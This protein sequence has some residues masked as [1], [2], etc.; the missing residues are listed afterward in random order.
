METNTNTS[1]LSFSKG[2]TT[3][4]SGLLSEDS[5]LV[6]SRN[7]IYR[8]GE[9]KP[10]QKPV[11]IG[12]VSADQEIKFIHKTAGY[13]NVITYDGSSSV[14]WYKKENGTIGSCEG[15]FN[16]G[17]VYDINAVGNT[18]VVATEKGLHYLLFKSGKYKDLGTELPIPEFHPW[19]TISN[20]LMQGRSPATLYGCTSCAKTKYGYYVDED[21]KPYV[22]E[23]HTKPDEV[24]SA[25]GIVNTLSDYYKISLP[26]DD[27]QEYIDKVKTFH[28]SLQGHVAEAINIAKE[29]NKFVG[30]FFIRFALKLFDGSY[31]RISNPIACYPIIRRGGIIRG[32]YWNT[33]DDYQW[34]YIV[35]SGRHDYWGTFM[36]QIYYG[37]LGYIA[38]INN[39]SDWTDIVKELVVFASDDVLP[40]DVEQYYELVDAPDMYGRLRYDNYGNAA[41]NSEDVKFIPCGGVV[42]NSLDPPDSATD[43][44]ISAA[45]TL[46][47]PSEYKTDSQ[48]RDELITKSQFY[49][50]FSIKA[51]DSEKLNW[52]SHSASE[53]MPSKVVANLTNQEQLPKDDYYGWCSMAAKSLYSYNSRLNVFDMERS[54]WKGFNFF[55]A[56]TYSQYKSLYKFYVHISS[57]TIDTW[58]E[59]DSGKMA[60]DAAHGWFYYPDP[61]A[62]EVLVYKKDAQQGFLV[63]LTTHPYLNGSY[64]FIDLPGVSSFT[65]VLGDVT[66]PTIDTSAREILDSQ[67]FTSV[68][69]NPFVFEASGDNTVGTG[70]ILGI[71][72]NVE[73]ISQGQFGQYPL[74]VFTTDGIYAMAVSSEGLYSSIYPMSREV[75]DNA[76]SITQTDR[77]AFF[78]SKKGLMAVSG[79]TVYPMSELMV[80][81]SPRNFSSLD[82]SFIKFLSKCKIAYDYRG[83]LLWIFS[84]KDGEKLQWQ[85]V[86]NMTDKTFATVDYGLLCKAIIND[87]P[88]N[89][90]QV[91]NGDVYSLTSKPEINE[92]E[93]VYEGYFT[94]RPLK[95]GSSL[96]IKSIRK[97]KHFIDTD[98]GKLDLEVWG[99]NNTRN[100]QKLTSLLGKPWTFFTLK[101]T[102]KN[103][104]AYDSFSGTIVETQNRRNAK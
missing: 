16:V 1:T 30:S 102:L 55:T 66:L 58:V 3:V 14:Y 63:Q 7:F 83:G 73:P 81:R 40:F 69:N 39:I 100:W 4:P 91:S 21:G 28:E 8:N 78:T 43:E 9:M 52:N 35:K 85:Y 18:L 94:T 59:S 95:L 77:L 50:L 98:E 36:Y 26:Y 12:A 56:E 57:N 88:D 72:A 5:E 37:D 15:S 49:K 41:Y 23:G 42:D 86:F 67:I 92:D 90:I 79:G 89:L 48:I 76:D 99:S 32:L 75:C 27:D 80:G 38:R 101:Y 24:G 45:N 104:K 103:F 29:N 44:K 61:N 51:T 70:S 2:M 71:V 33:L 97:I 22:V 54:P 25:A 60:D 84:E 11:K 82:V 74:F 31:A 93:N 6:E 20:K 87:Y 68:V 64:C 62:S 13:E 10:I 46:I 47:A 17:T 53:I 34:D 19:F 96:L 65:N